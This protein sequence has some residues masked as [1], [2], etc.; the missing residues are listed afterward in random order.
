MKRTGFPIL[1]AVGLCVTSAGLAQQT[2][3]PAQ[4]PP[5]EP[6]PATTPPVA[7]HPV[8]LDVVVTD[9]SGNPVPGL[10]QQDFTLLDDKQPQPI[11][12]F[13]AAEGTKDVPVQAMM[14]IDAVNTPFTGVAIQRTGIDKFLRA[15]G[16]E[17]PIPMSIILLTDKSAGQ[18]LTTLH[19]DDLA[20]EL[21][22]QEAAI[23]TITRS[24]GYYGAIERLQTSIK[25]LE[26][27]VSNIEPRTGRKLL[28]WVGPGWPLV[29]GPR[30]QLTNKDREGLFNMAVELSTKLREARIT[31][32]SINPSG[33]TGS[34]QNEYFY[35][36]FVKGV[37]NANR[38]QNGNL[39]VQVLAVQ[40][41]GM[42]INMNNDLPSSLTRCV[43]DYKAFYTLTF[44]APA[45]DHSDE[46]H[47]LEVKI[48]KRGL[49][50][51]TR[52]GYYAQ[53]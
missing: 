6:R 47:S 52:T 50:A 10:Q 39:G 26:Q 23:R 13:H 46:Y 9:R 4:A 16:G 38:I 41:G 35:E 5:L 33:P 43:A 8:V 45:A 27:I 42:V 31:L 21:D 29:S 34:M 22:A 15:G 49:T 53:P 20:G 14:V 19:G 2:A 12:D 32:Y 44:N 51:R 24:A 3:P 1:L 36:D 11:V 40:T 37:P 30:V 48:D 28:I 18:S 7:L 25:G 17:L